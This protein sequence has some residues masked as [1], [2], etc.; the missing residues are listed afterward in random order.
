MKNRTSMKKPIILNTKAQKKTTQ[1]H[2]EKVQEIPVEEY[3]K[4]RAVMLFILTIG[5]IIGFT[6]P[7]VNLFFDKPPEIEMTLKE[8]KSK[9]KE[10]FFIGKSLRELTN[11]FNDGL[12]SKDTFIAKNKLIINEFNIKHDEVIESNTKYLT[13]I[14]DKEYFKFNNFKTFIFQLGLI[15]SL[16]ICSFI[17]LFLSIFF[18]KN[19][20]S[21]LICLISW[22]LITTPSIFYLFWVFYPLNNLPKLYYIYTY[23]LI[24]VGV[25]IFIMTIHKALFKFILKR[26]ELKTKIATLLN[27]VSVIRH[28]HF[29]KLAKKSID[30]PLSEEELIQDTDNL[31][32]EIYSKFEKII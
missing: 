6:A 3:I 13:T 24:L 28:D 7:M 18:V 27:L 12:I 15:I 32:K 23:S 29:F 21:K 4:K 30:G 5:S 26:V 11:D 10:R 17:I 8:L 14:K 22:A 9:K 25:V 31:D 2:Q 1:H 20:L 16:L 19:K